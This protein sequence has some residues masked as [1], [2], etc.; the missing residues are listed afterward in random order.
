MLLQSLE[1]IP[2]KDESHDEAEL[3]VKD[4][5]LKIK[6]TSEEF[7]SGWRKGDKLIPII[8][9]VVDEEEFEKFHTDLGLAMKVI[10]H[11]KEDA[12]EVIKETN[13]RKIDRDTAFFLNRA[14]NHGL[15]YEEKNGGIDMC[16]AM[17]KKAEKDKIS[18][19]IEGM[20]YMGA[21]DNDIIEK[22]IEKYHVTKE[23]VLALL[24]PQNA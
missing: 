16:L 12:D 14:V 8:T 13:H 10:K 1:A 19:V 6:L 22:I 9:A 15:K 23:Y 7:L 21:S 20:K 24:T 11:Q 2:A 3:L 4:G 5:T 18:G 17:E